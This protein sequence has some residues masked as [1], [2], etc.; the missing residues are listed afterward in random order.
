MHDHVDRTSPP[1][2]APPDIGPSGAGERVPVEAA[3][4]LPGGGAR[5]ALVLVVAVAAGLRLLAATR[6][7]AHLDGVTIP[8]DAYLALSIA[9]NI[10]S[11]IGPFYYPD[12]TNG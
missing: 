3:G 6:P 4:G 2:V 5:W 9:R 8:D 12:F 7:V 11:G 1:S 10:A